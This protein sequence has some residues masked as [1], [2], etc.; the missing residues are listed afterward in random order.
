MPAETTNAA[1]P[2]EEALRAFVADPFGAGREDLAAH[3]YVCEA[4]QK[5]MEGMLHPRAEDALTDEDRAVIRAF[6]QRHCKRTV[7]ERL[8]AFVEARQSVFFDTGASGWRMAAASGCA[9]VK[10][11]AEPFEDVRFVFL[12]EEDVTPCD[13][14]RAELEIPGTASGETPLWI[15]VWNRDDEPAEDGSFSIAGAT[16]PVEK[17]KATIP[18]DLFLVG[19]R[20]SAVAYQRKG[21]MSVAGNLVFF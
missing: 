18:L 2:G 4:C 16:V 11:E 15:K 14:W 13:R 1:C 9:G 20:N 21:G 5:R 6:T 8:D 19:I 3:V 12:S 10:A 17:G 7:R